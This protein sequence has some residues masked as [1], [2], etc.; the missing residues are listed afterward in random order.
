M[1]GQRR[2]GCHG[3]GTT[4]HF[5]GTPYETNRCPRRHLL[6][7]PDLVE[8]YTLRRRTGEAVGLDA[9]DKLSTAAMDALDTVSDAV[10]W[11]LDEQMKKHER[12]AKANR[13]L[14]GGGR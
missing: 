7:N 2:W 8:V 12:E 13:D 4:I 3:G 5:P 10:A 6:D 14:K 1:Q 9:G 11:R